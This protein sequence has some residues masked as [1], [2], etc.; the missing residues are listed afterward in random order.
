VVSSYTKLV[1]NLSEK[2]LSILSASPIDVVEND[3]S[4]V[5]EVQTWELTSPR[6]D[7][8][9]NIGSANFMLATDAIIKYVHESGDSNPYETGQLVF[10][11]VLLNLEAHRHIRQSPTLKRKG[12]K[13]ISNDRES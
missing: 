11:S 3:G 1:S 10:K 6:E 9:I 7:K 8:S 13:I 2:V 4:A 12:F 5:Y